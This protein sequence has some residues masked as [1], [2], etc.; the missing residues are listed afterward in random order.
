MRS[1]FLI[2]RREYMERVHT[3]AFIFSLIF[4]PA[5][6]ALAIAVPAYFSS[7]D[8][9]SKNSIVVTSDA[10]LGQALTAELAASQD[11][12][13]LYFTLM[14]PSPTLRAQLNAQVEAKQIE[15]YLWLPDA[16]AASA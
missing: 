5:I 15:G 11:A 8:A 1:I 14:Q 6:M 2:A 12:G 7:H 10:A 3:K 13:G 16:D 4:F 9:A